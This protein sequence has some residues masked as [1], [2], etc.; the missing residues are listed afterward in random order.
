V[1]SSVETE[2]GRRW[3]E[4]KIKALT[5]GDKI[6]ARFMRQDFFYFTPQFK[7]I[8]AGNHKPGLRSVDEAIRRRFF[9]IPFTVTIPAEERDRDLSRKL[10]TEWPGILQWMIAGCLEWQRTGLAAPEKVMAATAEYLEAQDAIAAW[11]ADRADI[12]INHFET[13]AALWKSWIEWADNTG[14]FQ[15]KRKEFV[16]RLENR[17]GVHRTRQGKAQDLGF[18]GLSL[19]A[20]VHRL[21]PRMSLADKTDK[22]K[23]YFPSRARVTKLTFSFVCFVCLPGCR[24]ATRTSCS[25]LGSLAPPPV[26]FF[27]TLR[28]H[29]PSQARTCCADSSFAFHA[30]S[31]PQRRPA[32]D[33]IYACAAHQARS[34]TGH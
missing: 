4:S 20:I 10:E 14:E 26:N 30:C 2:E 31:R 29:R 27:V 15:G 19:A 3:A 28:P 17:A 9:L 32:V 11:I 16:A 24:C 33:N 13:A 5:G 18:A 6:S 1:V 25:P 23:V 34:A 8:I 12:D 7:L 22:T 21:W